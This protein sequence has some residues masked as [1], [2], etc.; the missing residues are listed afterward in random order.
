LGG[1]GGELIPAVIVQVFGRISPCGLSKCCRL[2]R[3]I[4]TARDILGTKNNVKQILLKITNKTR[5][6]HFVYFPY[7]YLVENF[8][9]ITPASFALQYKLP[10]AK[11]IQK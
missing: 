3:Q 10:L 4:Y 7:L 11:N 6:L 2:I 5:G 9:Y 8:I 1:E